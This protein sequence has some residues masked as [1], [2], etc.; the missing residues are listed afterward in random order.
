MSTIDSIYKRRSVRKYDMTPLDNN[1]MNEI[2]GLL[3]NLPA[4]YP[5]IPFKAEI[6][7]EGAKI[8]NLFSGIVNNY[9]KVVAPHYIV[10]TGKTTDGYL[11]NIGFALEEAVLTLTSMEIGTCWIGGFNKKADFENIITFEE[12]FVPVIIIAFGKPLDILEVTTPIAKEYKRK[13]LLEIFIGDLNDEL[14]SIG[15][16]VLRAPSGINGQPWR[17]FVNSNSIDVYTIKRSF[18]LKSLEPMNRIDAGIA[19]R[20]MVICANYLGKNIEFS[21][22]NKKEKDGYYYITTGNLK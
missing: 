19:L 20:H 11:E 14:K 6:L 10:I 21:T 22:E 12:G 4:L 7:R 3:K 8:S 15:D 5:T 16:G 18:I 13:D 17:F 2:D 9:T 1:T